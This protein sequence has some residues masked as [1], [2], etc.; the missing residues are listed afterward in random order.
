MHVQG[1]LTLADS[2]TS[3][4]GFLADC[5]IFDGQVTSGSGAAK[6]FSA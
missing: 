1:A 5:K 6:W 4:G 2:G 3:S